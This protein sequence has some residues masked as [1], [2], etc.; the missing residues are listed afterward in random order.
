MLTSCVIYDVISL[1]HR[2][3]KKSEKSIKIVD[4]D[5][6]NLHI[7]QTTWKNHRRDQIDPQPFKG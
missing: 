2:Y 6:E 5:G 3:V 4:I 7:F 1:Q